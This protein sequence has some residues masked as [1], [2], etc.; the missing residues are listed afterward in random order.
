MNVLYGYYEEG[1]FDKD[2]VLFRIE[3]C[4]NDAMVNKEREIIYMQVIKSSV[5]HGSTPVQFR[6]IESQVKGKQ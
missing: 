3:G 1:K 4:S 6:S 5:R 2:V